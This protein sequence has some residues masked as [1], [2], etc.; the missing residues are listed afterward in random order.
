MSSPLYVL[1]LAGGSGERFWPLSRRTR[2]KQLLNLFSEQTLLES[3]LARLDGLVPPENVLVL[4]N[5][6][7]LDGVRAVARGVPAENIV[8]EPAKRDT[9]AAIALGVGWVAARQPGATMIV[10]PADHLIRDIAGFQR[11]LRTAAHAAAQTSELV[12]IGIKPTWPC[13]GFGYIEVGAPHPLRD[14]PAG[15]AVHDVV[16]FREKPSTELAEQ[17]L[18]QGTFRWNAGMFV[19]SIQAILNA[20]ERYAPPL[21]EFV[22]RVRTGDFAALLRDAFPKLPKISI[23]YAVMEKAGRVLVVE[24]DFDWDDIGSWTAVAKYLPEVEAQ[25][26]SN[27]EVRLHDATQNIVFSNGKKLVALM[28]VHDLIV[29]ETADALLVCNRHDAEQIKQLVALAPPE[30]Q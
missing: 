6:D 24:A 12:T 30:L 29:V 20:F 21:A 4:T 23:D 5:A 8:A 15:P 7:Q 2:P 18:A 28:G 19:W 17:F 3:T 9:A 16:R 27:T 22:G 25:N 11:T 10:L 26:R 13:P 14:A 1:V